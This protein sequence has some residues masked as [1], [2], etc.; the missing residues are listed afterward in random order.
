MATVAARAKLAWVS[1]GWEKDHY[2]LPNGRMG[3]R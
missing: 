3:L 1:T 2:C